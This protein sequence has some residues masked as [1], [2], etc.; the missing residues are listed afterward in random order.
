MHE[1]AAQSFVISKTNFNMGLSIT[2]R[3]TSIGRVKL[4]PREPLFLE[5]CHGVPQ[6]KQVKQADLVL[7]I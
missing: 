1:P 4:I 3:S 6:K 7:C 2:V 5:E